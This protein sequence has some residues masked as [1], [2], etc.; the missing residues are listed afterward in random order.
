[1]KLSILI[2]MY[3]EAQTAKD[4]ALKLKEKLE[5]VFEKGEWEVVF[6]DDGSVDDCRKIVDGLHLDGIRTVGYEKNKGKGGAVRYG[7][8]ECKGDA[9]VYTDCDLA[10]GVDQPVELYNSL[11]DN[12]ICIGS[13]A[14]HPDGYT[15]YTAAR[16]IMSK[17]Y[18]KTISLISGFKH[19][20]SQ[21]GLKCLKR[22]CAR[23]IFSRCT[24]NGFAFDLEMLILAD[25]LHY[26]VGEFPAKII[27]NR[28]RGSKVN[29]L[30][31]SVKMIK[32]VMNIKKIHKDVK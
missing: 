7:I 30:K 32:D 10:Y 17:A 2:P 27:C 11:G 28:D 25:K 12:D 13:R 4:C 21:A 24:V 19:S 3:N 6:C 1:M 16:K 5:S 26:K 29:P 22:E 9:I 15:G 14:I 20:D 31:D 8:M 18:L 23:D